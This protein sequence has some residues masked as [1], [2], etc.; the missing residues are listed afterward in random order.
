M[1]P[2]STDATAPQAFVTPDT[3]VFSVP[4]FLLANP[5]GDMEQ[6]RKEAQEAGFEF[7]GEGLVHECGDWQAF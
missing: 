2:Q 3:D 4:H 7:M 5:E 1:P 6:A